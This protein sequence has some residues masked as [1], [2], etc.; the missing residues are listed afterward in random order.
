MEPDTLTHAVPTVLAFAVLAGAPGP[1]TLSVAALAMARGRNRALALAAG[2]ML[3]LA[4]WGLLAMLGLG[5]LLPRWAGALTAL[6]LVGGAY[7]LWLAWQSARSALRAAP[8]PPHRG[9]GRGRLF[10]RSL[11]LNLLNP[12]AALAWVATLVLASPDG[13]AGPAALAGTTLVCALLG[14]AIYLLYATVFST[15]V[16][17]AGYAR[18]RRGIEGALAL[19]FGAA[20]LR[21]LLARL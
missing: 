2:L 3:G 15:P 18:F 7:L 1:A 14:G 19:L 20:G 10:R 4:A 8:P 6:K 17:M 5:A 9:D 12:K 13:A 16:L 11:L 21:L